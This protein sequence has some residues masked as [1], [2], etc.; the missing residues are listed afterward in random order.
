MTALADA[1]LDGAASS[2]R[3]LISDLYPICRSITGDGVRRTIERVAKDLPL[4]VREVASGTQVFDW[5]VPKEWNIR[6]A[7]IADATGRR[8]VDFDASNLHVVSY[9]VPMHARMALSELRPHL[10][11]LP[12]QPSVVPYRTSYYHESWGFCLSHD[13]LSTLQEGEY[14]VF[15]DSTLDDG[16]LTFAECVIPGDEPDEVLLS[17]H[18][19]H[20]SLCNDN[21]SGIALVTFLGGLLRRCETRFTY[22][23]IFIPGTIGSITWLALN[24]AQVGRIRHGLVVS[25]VGDAGPLTYKRSR[26]H[27]A[28]VD[29]AMALVLERSGRPHQVLD[30]DPYGYDERQFCSPGFDLPV[31]RISRSVYGTYPEYHTSAD[32]LEFVRDDALVDTLS[33]VTET[34]DLLERDRRYV[35]LNPKCEPQLGRRGLYRA[36]GGPNA[37]SAEMALLWLLNLADGRASVIDIV[38]RSGLPPRAV[39]DAVAALLAHGLIEEVGDS[40]A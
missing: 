31:G 34:L 16:A 18:I 6:S 14:E 29:R 21:L 7:W 28:A 32:D 9:S 33:A 8:V 19:C 12:D 37:A 39:H 24:E 20:P 27:D 3:S 1:Q 4:E 25:G 30:F 23:L 2:M 11:S 22:R 13:T 40:P 26:Q 15:I 10:H 38:E 5:T 17:C 35:N 36:I